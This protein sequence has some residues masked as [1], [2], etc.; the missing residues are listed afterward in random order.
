MINLP[1]IQTGHKGNLLNSKDT[2]KLEELLG[3][4]VESPFSSSVCP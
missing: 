3:W 4:V 2:Y 1:M